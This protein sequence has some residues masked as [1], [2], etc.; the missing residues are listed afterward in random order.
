MMKSFLSFIDGDRF[1]QLFD[2]ILNGLFLFIVLFCFPYFFF[3]I[4]SLFR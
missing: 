1:D 2:K 4:L 3:T